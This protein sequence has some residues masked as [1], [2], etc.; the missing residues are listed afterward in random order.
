MSG[1]LKSINDFKEMTRKA[2][3]TEEDKRKF[4]HGY[5]CM[6][7]LYGEGPGGGW[8]INPPPTHPKDKD[9]AFLLG[10]LVYCYENTVIEPEAR[11]RLNLMSALDLALTSR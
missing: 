7:A 9:P 11:K 8:G 2:L 3:V 4:L 10:K 5:E 6:G 1:S